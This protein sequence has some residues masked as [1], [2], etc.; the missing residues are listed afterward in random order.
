MSNLTLIKSDKFGETECDIYSDNNEMYM[1]LSQLSNCLGYASKDSM[2]SLLSRNDYLKEPEFSK[3]V[4]ICNPLDNSEIGQSTRVFTEDG[5]YEVTMLAKTEKAKQFR[6]W[7]RKLLKSL[8][9]GEITAVKTD[10]LN[11]M[12]IRAA[13]DRAAAMR[14]NAENRR[15]KLLLEHPHLK[16]LSPIAQ[17]TWELK[18][19]EAATGKDVGNLLPECGELKQAGQLAAE[20]T[21]EFGVKVT[22]AML[23]KLA[24][25]NGLKTEEYGVM[26][27]DKSP[28]SNKEV[29]SFRYNAKGAAK[30][31]EFAKCYY[32]VD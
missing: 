28:Y 3:V 9:S 5:I 23:G 14:M 26:A 24:N 27:M 10:K 16:D 8:R 21:K 7:V 32:L 30:L 1:T 17:Q 12:K 29:P 31:K 18:A 13:A 4:S 6:S 25:Q 11:E 19:V 20:W 2:K 15:L 22:S